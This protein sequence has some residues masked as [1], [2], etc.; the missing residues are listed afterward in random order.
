MLT[1]N[2]Q[3]TRPGEQ[4]RWGQCGMEQIRWCVA[5]VWVSENI[6]FILVGVHGPAL[7]L[8]QVSAEQ[9]CGWLGFGRGDGP[10]KGVIFT[11]TFIGIEVQKEHLVKP[12][13]VR[14]LFCKKIP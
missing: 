4:Q 10:S 2:V 12:L 8:V 5:G 9:M 11:R 7:I 1:V 6:A 13:A 14:R 3:L